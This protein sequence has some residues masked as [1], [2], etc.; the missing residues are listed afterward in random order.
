[1]NI[2]RNELQLALERVV[3]IAL[4]RN[5]HLPELPV[6]KLNH[7]PEQAEAQLLATRLPT[8]GQPLNKTFDQVFDCVLKEAPNANGPR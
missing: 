4:D 5:D 2:S 7:N 8:T 6:V 3:Q 1:M